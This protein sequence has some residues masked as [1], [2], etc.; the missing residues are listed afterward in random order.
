[1]K[2]KIYMMHRSMNM[3]NNVN[4][5]K[6]KTKD[7]ELH[8]SMHYTNDEHKKYST[9]SVKINHIYMATS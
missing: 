1:M 2:L 6:N 5:Q 9:Q 8:Q 4:V 7:H 3:I